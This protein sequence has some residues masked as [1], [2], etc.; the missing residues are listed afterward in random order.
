MYPAIF[1]V[2]KCLIFS[3][4]SKIDNIS[5]K[6][7]IQKVCKFGKTPYLCISSLKY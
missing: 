4:L 2:L 1:Y 5:A 7:D 3:N 6:K